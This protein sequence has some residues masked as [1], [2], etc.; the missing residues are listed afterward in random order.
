MARSGANADEKDTGK[1]AL[2]MGGGLLGLEAAHS[3]IKAGW[4]VCV[5]EYFPQLLPR[6]LSSEA[7][8]KVQ[9]ILEG[10]GFD[11]KLGRTVK[12]VEHTN[13]NS[14]ELA[15]SLDN[16][17]LLAADMVLASAGV[18]S[19]TSLA[20]AA[21]LA[22]D[23]GIVVDERFETSVKGIYALGDCAQLPGGAIPGLWMAAMSQADALA[24]I[25]AGSVKGY[26]SPVFKPVVKIPGVN[27]QDL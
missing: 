2:V 12:R 8:A 14:R 22:I 20:A 5:V 15:I 7:G 9:A 1:R 24:G 11:F 3:L 13:K 23:K 25:L 19:E 26:E 18:R 4:S 27:M 10:L 6:Q 16:G 17:E 21:V